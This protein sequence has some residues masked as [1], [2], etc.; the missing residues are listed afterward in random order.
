VRHERPTEPWRTLTTR[1]RFLRVLVGAGAAPLA[2]AALFLSRARGAREEP[3]VIEL[4][5]PG[6]DGVTFY[7]EAIL[8]RAGPSPRAYSSRCPHLGCRIGRVDGAA[9]VCPCHGSRF[10]LDGHVLAGPA[11]RDLTPLS[12]HDGSKPGTLEIVLAR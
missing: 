2:A 4:P 3:K 9:L 6:A 5:A 11:A 7:R 8:V 12:I 10:D 1:R